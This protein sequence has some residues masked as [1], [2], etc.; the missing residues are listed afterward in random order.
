MRHRQGFT[1]VELLVVI[2]IIAVLISI[3]LPSLAKA[4]QSALVVADLSNL[5]QVGN[6]V[7]MYANENKGAFP[8]ASVYK[9][10]LSKIL[11]T[12][13][14]TGS[15]VSKA[16]R[17]VVAPT[18]AN[19]TPFIWW[20]SWTWNA[21][22]ERWSWIG[23][24]RLFA[25]IGA[26]DAAT[27]GTSKCPARKISSVRSSSEKILMWDHGVCDWN[28]YSPATSL[29][30]SLDNWAFWNS[31]GHCWT[32]PAADGSDLNQL[33]GNGGSGRTVT[34]IA[35]D[36]F[37]TNGQYDSPMRYRHNNNTTGV[38]LFV[39][40]HAE[41]RKIGEVLLRDVCVNR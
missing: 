1:L 20:P 38:F 33:C 36:N 17:S 18:D 3:L 19:T 13:P 6:A 31:S 27:N 28:N 9:M 22:D 7:M 14:G 5:K 34:G 41:S 8:L 2:G 12:D 40:G 30:Y 25:D 24:P 26:D 35:K 4:R 11:G 32:D 29:P 39:D 10:E 23:N 16:M 21:P 37:D 15:K